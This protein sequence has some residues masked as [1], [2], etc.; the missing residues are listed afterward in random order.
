LIDRA[1]VQHNGLKSRPLPIPIKV[2]NVDGSPN[3]A[4]HITEEVSFLVNYKGHK[5]IA[6]FEVTDLGKTH[7][8][9][10]QPWLYK[11]NPEI[12][13]QTGEIKFT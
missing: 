4:E 2:F 5:E 12:N 7:V 11:H 6:V 1:F 8:I 3:S 10:G 9:L 13:W